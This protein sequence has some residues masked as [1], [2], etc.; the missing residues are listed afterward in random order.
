MWGRTRDA[1]VDHGSAGEARRAGLGTRETTRRRRARGRVWAGGLSR[2]ERADSRVS[3]ARLH[4]TV[5]GSVT[6]ARTSAF[7][8]RSYAYGDEERQTEPR[9]FKLYAPESTNSM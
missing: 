4:G 2:A 3:G 6:H 5:T 9:K 8:P 1:S 7:A